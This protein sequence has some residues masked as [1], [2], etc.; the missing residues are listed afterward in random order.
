M[1]KCKSLKILIE[2]KRVKCHV[3]FA[4]LS[5]VSEIFVSFCFGN[6]LFYLFFVPRYLT[7]KNSPNQNETEC[8]STFCD[9]EK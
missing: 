2:S 9:D 8:R 3:A 5:L 7:S 1:A 6:F 4:D